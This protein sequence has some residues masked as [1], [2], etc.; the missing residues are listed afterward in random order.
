MLLS[1]Q[2]RRSHHR[3]QSPCFCQESCGVGEMEHAPFSPLTQ[4]SKKL[5]VLFG[6]MFGNQ[7][8]VELEGTWVQRQ[9]TD[10]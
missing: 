6:V 4:Q 7:K 10:S 5:R 3:A 9:G 2:E 8:E 1:D